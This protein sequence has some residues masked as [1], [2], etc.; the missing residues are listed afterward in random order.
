MKYAI[1]YTRIENPVIYVPIRHLYTCR[2]SSTNRPLFMQNKPNFQNMLMN[3]T[4]FQQTTYENI[5]PFGHP[6]NKPKTNPNKPNL[7]IGKNERKLS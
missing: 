6:K 5:R 7:K 4:A 1:R 3:A 2:E